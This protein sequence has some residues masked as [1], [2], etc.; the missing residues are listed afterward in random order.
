[1]VAR[2]R[3][4]AVNDAHKLVFEVHQALAGTECG[5]QDFHLEPSMCWPKTITSLSVCTRPARPSFLLPFNDR[6]FGGGF[7]DEVELDAEG[8]VPFL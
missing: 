3:V 6:S 2:G 1:M 7:S 4:P 5:H 8:V